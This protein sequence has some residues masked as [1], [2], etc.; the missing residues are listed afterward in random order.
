VP[1]FGGAA[2]A[3]AASMAVTATKAIREGLAVLLFNMMVLLFVV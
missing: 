3:A 1:S 2:L